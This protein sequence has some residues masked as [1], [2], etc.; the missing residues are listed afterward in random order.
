[1]PAYLTRFHRYNSNNGQ[2]RISGPVWINADNFAHA[3]ALAET[4]RA[5]MSDADPSCEYAII[6]IDAS[7]DYR[8]TD[9]EGGAR[10]WETAQELSTR[11]NETE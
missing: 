3:H 5:G 1:M 4:R 6:T 9:C 7:R 2:S 10:L 11:L 8:G